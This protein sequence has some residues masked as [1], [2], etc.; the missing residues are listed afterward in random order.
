[1]LR[2]PG[3]ACIFHLGTSMPLA[4]EDPPLS[5]SHVRGWDAFISIL[6]SAIGMPAR[7]QAS[8]EKSDGSSGVCRLPFANVRRLTAAM[9]VSRLLSSTMRHCVVAAASVPH[10]SRMTFARSLVATYRNR[11]RGKRAAGLDR[12]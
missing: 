7:K 11:G 2:L 12:H 4:R 5:C 6:L 9:I 10:F 1:I 8:V 3:N